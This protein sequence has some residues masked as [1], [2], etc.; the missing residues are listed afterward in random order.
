MYNYSDNN[1]NNDIF[2]HDCRATKIAFHDNM[3]SYIFKEGF[4]E[5]EINTTVY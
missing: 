1:E 5:R 3:L 2:L 4:W